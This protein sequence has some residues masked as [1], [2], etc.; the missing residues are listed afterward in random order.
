VSQIVINL[1][2]NAADAVDAR[3]D[4]ARRIALAVSE[5][6]GRGRIAVSDS[7]EGIPAELRDRIFEPFVSTKSQDVPRGFGLTVVREIVDVLG[8][9]IEVRSDVGVGSTFVISLPTVKA[10]G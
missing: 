2:L 1:L 9:E 7:G 5:G 3:P 10:A 6:A 8:G 4:G